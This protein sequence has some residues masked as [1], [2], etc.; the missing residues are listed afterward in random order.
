MS[1][2]RIYFKNY[3]VKKEGIDLK[4]KPKK[5]KLDRFSKILISIGILLAV[6]FLSYITYFGIKVY[7]NWGKMY[8]ERDRTEDPLAHIDTP[9]TDP[10]NIKFRPFTIVMLGIDSDDLKDGRSDTI[11][12]STVNPTKKEVSILSLPRDSYVYIPSKNEEDKINHAYSHKGAEGSMQTLENLL[13][14]KMDYYVSVN[15]KA[16]QKFVDEIGGI[17]VNVEDDFSFFDRISR[18]TVTFKKGKQKLNGAE[19]LNYARYR[20]GPDG[21]FGRIRRQQVVIKSMV[22]KAMS[23]AI[24]TKLPS[25]VDILGDHVKTDISLDNMKKLV[26]NMN[27]I[28][29]KNIHSLEIKGEPF[30]LNKTSYVR[31][32]E[33]DLATVKEKL[34]KELTV[35]K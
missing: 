22:D 25:I 24:L 33:N 6:S 16:V 27:D 23:P 34:K 3:C 26:T 21:D 4:Q 20:G 32:D 12:V 28:T 5:K 2:K 18:K 10:K 19:A 11:M 29:S 13:G 31:L 14:V 8:V 7:S 9:N 15:F 17:T 35:E 1:L 30:M